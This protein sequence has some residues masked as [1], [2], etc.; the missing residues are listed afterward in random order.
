MRVRASAPA[1]DIPIQTIETQQ[2]EIIPTVTSYPTLI[3]TLFPALTETI[4]PTQAQV[5]LTVTAVGG[6]L[7]IRR[8]PGLAYN[9][10]GV[11]EN[12]KSATALARDI[13]SNWVQISL[14]SAKNRTGWISLMTEY[15]SLS[16]DLK[17]LSAIEVTDWPLH[18][19]L[20]NCTY[21]NMVAQPGE[22]ILP[23]YFQR[24]ENEVRVYP[25]SYKIYDLD[26]PNTPE[27]ADVEI[28]EGMTIDITVNGDG[29]KRKCP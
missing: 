14:P 13:L 5:S 1:G 24:P 12:G 8:G 15:S 22:I 23:S 28:R 25:G 18:A 9:P 4:I 26:H 3:P 2:I 16:G 6:N 21:H 27:A 10:I 7:F 20:R 17:T 29:E 19:Y 11:L